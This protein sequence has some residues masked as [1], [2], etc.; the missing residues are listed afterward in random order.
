ML[1]I[2]QN[3][4]RKEESTPKEAK[5][6]RI[7]REKKRITRNKY[8]RL[9]NYFD[10]EG[11]MAQKCLWN[12]AKENIVKERGELSNKVGDAVSEYVAMHEE[13]FWSS[14]LR[15]DERGK[16]ERMAKAEKNEEERCEKMKRE[17]EK[18]ENETGTLR[19][20]REGFVSVGPFYFCGQG[21]DLESCGDLSWKTP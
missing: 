20:R 13:N 2:I 16:E 9:L 17:E 14:W 10:T 6:W 12:L 11:L 18:E 19:R 7:E 4:S 3:L 15:E 5:N 21:E 1:K 8:Q